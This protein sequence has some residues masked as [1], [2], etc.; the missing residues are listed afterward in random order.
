MRGQTFFVD[1]LFDLSCTD[2]ADKEV[3]EKKINQEV[4][5][6]MHRLNETAAGANSWTSLDEYA[7]NCAVRTVGTKVDG[8]YT[9]LQL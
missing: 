9:S 2:G 7:S 6:G 4:E 8:S 3:F 5:D 1:L